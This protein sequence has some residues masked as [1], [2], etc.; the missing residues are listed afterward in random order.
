[1]A[2]HSNSRRILDRSRNLTDSHLE[3]IA[4]TGGLAGLMFPGMFVHSD[5]V[6]VT[7]EKLME[8]LDHMLA[9]AGPDHVGLGSDF[10]G[11]SPVTGTCMKSPADIPRIAGH[12]LERGWSEEDTAKVMGGNW[13][14][15]IKTVCG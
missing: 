7:F 5:P 1:M 15:V 3:A 14:R 6:R 10:D 9:V 4:A 2:S 11:F 8:H 12:L 13:L